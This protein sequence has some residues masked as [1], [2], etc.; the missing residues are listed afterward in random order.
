MGNG[1]GTGVGSGVG[2][3]VG[4][5]VGTGVGS[6]VGPTDSKS[7]VRKDRNEKKKMHQKR[8]KAKKQLKYGDSV[9]K[10]SDQQNERTP[11]LP[12]VGAGVGT[13]VGDGVGNGVG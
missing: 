1:V 7:V 2:T 4:S 3:G 6:G 12:G 13:G 9:G 5:G 11:C 8:D 10:E